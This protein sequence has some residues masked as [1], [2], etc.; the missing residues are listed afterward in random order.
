MYEKLSFDTLRLDSLSSSENYNEWSKLRDMLYSLSLNLTKSS[1]AN[2]E[3][4]FLFQR[5]MLI[6]HYNA[7]RCACAENEQLDSISA[8]I[9]IS[10]LRYTDILASDKAFYEAGLMCKVM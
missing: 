7:M 9:S 1:E 6:S 2:S 3:A 4:G 10:L 5:L 8:K